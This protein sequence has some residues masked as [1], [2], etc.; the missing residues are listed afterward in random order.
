M[1]DELAVVNARLDA[2]IERLDRIVALL[3]EV[4]TSSGEPNK[5]DLL[6]RQLERGRF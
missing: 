1:T 2:I 3:A 4:V 6:A 5:L